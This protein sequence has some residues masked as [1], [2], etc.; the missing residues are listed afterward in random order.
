MFKRKPITGCSVV[1]VLIS[2][3]LSL[4]AAAQQSTDDPFATDEISKKNPF[5]SDSTSQ[6]VSVAA[7]QP[8]KGIKKQIAPSIT[9]NNRTTESALDRNVNGGFD[10]FED[11][12]EDVLEDLKTR[13]ETEFKLDQSAID[14]NL[15]EDTPISVTMVGR[16]SSMLDTMLKKYECTYTIHDGIVYIVSSD[17]AVSERWLQLRDIDCQY[18]IENRFGGDGDELVKFIQDMVSPGSWSSNGGAGRIRHV[19]GQ[20]FVLQNSINMRRVR[21]ALKRLAP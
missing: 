12:F 2:F 5:D 9:S 7:K 6:A 11:R 3:A 1:V 17:A 16:T 10:F 20:L 18:V 15:D 14:N 13:L 8:R 19:D 21:H 4:T